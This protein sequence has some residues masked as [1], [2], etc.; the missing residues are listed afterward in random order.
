MSSLRSLLSLLLP[1]LLLAVTGWF[2]W[3]SARVPAL[4]PADPSPGGTSAAA[5]GAW[6]EVDLASVRDGGSIPGWEFMRGSFAVVDRDGRRVLVMQPDPMVDGKVVAFQ[7]LRG[8]GA[9]RARMT[10]E[11]TRRARP[12]FGVGMQDHNEFQFRAV[13]QTSVI[14]LT[15]N[16]QVVA[17]APWEWPGPGHRLWLELR[18]EPGA[19]GGSRLEGRCW[20]EGA[21]RPEAPGVTFERGPSVGFLR[22]VIRGAPYAL[23]TIEIDSIATLQIPLSTQAKPAR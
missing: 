5:A 6:T 4:A 21:P 23:K 22:P 15:I 13:P 7:S 11:A 3:W 1:L 14:E 8:G 17:S 18:V 9:V 16:E 20:A 19:A 12:R 10:G 2:W